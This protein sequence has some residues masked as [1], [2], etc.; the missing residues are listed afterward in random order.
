M[1]KS[2]SM[3]NI[4][5]YNNE[6]NHDNYNADNFVFPFY[7]H[8]NLKNTMMIDLNKVS[9]STHPMRSEF[10]KINS[11]IKYNKSFKPKVVNSSEDYLFQKFKHKNRTDNNYKK[12]MI[13]EKQKIRKKHYSENKSVKQHKHKQHNTNKIIH[14]QKSPKL[15]KQIEN[16]CHKQSN[17]NNVNLGMT[18]MN[19]VGLVVDK[20]KSTTNEHIQRNQQNNLPIS[21]EISYHTQ[22]NIKQ[23]PIKSKIENLIQNNKNKYS[24]PK[25]IRTP[26]PFIQS[27]APVY[28]DSYMKSIIRNTMNINHFKSNTYK[29]HHNYSPN[30]KN[31]FLNYKDKYDIELFEKEFKKASNKKH[32]IKQSASALN[33]GMFNDLLYD[34]NS[35]SMS[36]KDEQILNNM[37]SKIPHRKYEFQSNSNKKYIYKRNTNFN[38]N[39]HSFSTTTHI[40]SNFSVM[41]PNEY[42]FVRSTKGIF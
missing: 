6:N 34:I 33:L 21:N 36:N 1:R 37:L 30:M 32:T 25:Q 41:P 12:Q 39:N 2:Q 23:N 40:R 8:N 38:N 20:L 24:T 10:V 14:Q 35:K 11:N 16:N 9:N 18:K 22:K 31:E 42:S 13:Q 3:E 15:N 7:N 29:H 26:I 5:K 27:S 28:K 19:D 4:Q 17:D